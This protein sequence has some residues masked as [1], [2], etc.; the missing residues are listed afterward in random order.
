MKSDLLPHSK[1]HF[2]ALDSLRGICATFV[3]IYHFESDAFIRQVPFIQHGFLFVDFFFVL[4]GFVIAANYRDKIASEYPILKFLF[5]RLGRLYPLYVSMLF[6]FLVLAALK[7]IFEVKSGQRYEIKPFLETLFMLQI[8]IPYEAGISDSWNAPGWSISGEFWAYI[9]FAVVCRITRGRYVIAFAAIAVIAI[10][11]ILVS[12]DRYLKVEQGAGGF[13]RCALGFSFGVLAYQ[14]WATG[15]VESLKPRSRMVMTA[16][17][18]A[19]C[20]LALFLVSCAGLA[21][22]LC[23]LIFSIAV[24]FFAAGGGLLGRLFETRP[25]VLI[26]TLSY[27]I[28]LTHEFILARYLNIIQLASKRFALPVAIDPNHPY[29][30]YNAPGWG[31]GWSDLAI[32]G[33]YLL[34]VAISVMTYRFIEAPWR[35]RSRKF[36][37]TG[38]GTGFKLFPQARPKGHRYEDDVSIS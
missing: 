19:V 5:L 24:L 35:E 26:G 11:V 20:G 12:T 9:L 14:V 15:L 17:V 29:G 16:I 23:P 4:S 37:T 3:V 22:M 18:C 7:Y 1:N 28:Y 30:L 36:A 8:W 25:F 10:P 13:A 32:I 34:V 6:A 31:V 27:S 2:L 38:F 33:F 21:S